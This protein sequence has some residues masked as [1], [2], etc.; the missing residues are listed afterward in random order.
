MLATTICALAVHLRRHCESRQRP[1]LR[2]L[3]GY[4]SHYKRRQVQLLTQ[5]ATNRWVSAG[6]YLP[7]QWTKIT[8]D[9]D[10][11]NQCMDV[12]VDD[13]KTPSNADPI[14]FLNNYDDLNTVSLAYQSVTSQNNTAPMYIDDL[15]I[16]GK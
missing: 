9:I 2:E 1:W 15:V 7:G 8:L 10:I 6:Y 16:H 4:L 14:P 13:A 12:Y 11:P 3:C 5:V